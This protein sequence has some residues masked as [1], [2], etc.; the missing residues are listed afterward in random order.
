MNLYKNHV[1]SYDNRDIHLG[2]I[3]VPNHP[4]EYQTPVNT[5]R[6]LYQNGWPACGAHAGATLKA[7]QEQ[8]D[9]Q[10]TDGCS[11]R[12]LWRFIKDIDGYAPE[13]GTDMRSIF[14][15]LSTRGICLYSTMPNPDSMTNLY[16]YTNPTITSEV[17]DEAN[18]MII[19]GYGF[20]PKGFSL[21]DLKD[22]IYKNAAVILLIN[23]DDGF[24]GTN[25]PTFTTRPYG[26][27]VVATGY[28]S[29]RVVI[30]DSTEI[31][32]KFSVKYI[33]NQY[34]PFI[35]EAGTAIDESTEKIRTMIKQKNILTKMVELYK[36]VI[37]LLKK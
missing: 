10:L 31:D 27:F 25:Y 12:C 1:R 34:F 3:S 21:E 16:A 8:K 19:N 4:V 18:T 6:K 11:P 2:M 36:Q 15:A 22:A 37:A 17:S 24:F 26:H 7:I 5:I 28:D 9:V 35:R 32:E 14:K 33:Y 13:V 30:L 29:Q 20:L 23:C